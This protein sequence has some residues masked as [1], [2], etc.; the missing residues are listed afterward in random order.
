MS[1]FASLDHQKPRSAIQSYAASAA[2]PIR[3]LVL[4]DF[5]KATGWHR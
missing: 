2:Y 5:C 3:R 1:M 4:H